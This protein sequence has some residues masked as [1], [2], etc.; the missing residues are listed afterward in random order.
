MGNKDKKQNYAENINR[1]N[2]IIDR[3][4]TK[5]IDIDEMIRLV[6]EAAE[7]IKS[8]QVILGNTNMVIQNALNDISD[9]NN[10]EENS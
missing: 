8:C 5:D 9:T 10:N 4:K 2:T 6:Q 7:L 3:L 1:I